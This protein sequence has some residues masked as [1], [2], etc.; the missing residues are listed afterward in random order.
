MIQCRD[1]FGNRAGRLLGRGPDGPL[2]RRQAEGEMTN[3][4]SGRMVGS[5]REQA[6][7]P[8]SGQFEPGKILAILGGIA[9][10]A[11]TV[12]FLALLVGQMG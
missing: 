7:R 3:M 6:E 5:R 9:V 10:V 11:A 4:E 8:E 2:F 1:W 12:V